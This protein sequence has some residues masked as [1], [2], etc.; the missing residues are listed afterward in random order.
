MNVLEVRYRTLY[1]LTVHPRLV[2]RGEVAELFLRL[3]VRVRSDNA[4]DKIKLR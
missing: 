1:R 4:G 2:K 3:R